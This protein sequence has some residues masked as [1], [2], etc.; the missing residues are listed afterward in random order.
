MFSG[1]TKDDVLSGLWDLGDYGGHAGTMGETSS[2]YRILM[3]ESL[4]V[5]Y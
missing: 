1:R 2:A 3:V 5:V 4:R